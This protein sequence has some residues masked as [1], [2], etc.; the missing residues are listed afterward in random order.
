MKIRESGQILKAIKTIGTKQLLRET[1]QIRGNFIIYYIT[2]INNNIL[3]ERKRRFK[4]KL[5]GK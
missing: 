3:K 2:Y 5:K 4:K 1:R